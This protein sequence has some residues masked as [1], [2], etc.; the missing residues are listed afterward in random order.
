M[1]REKFDARGEYLKHNRG[2]LNRYYFCSQCIKPLTVHNME[3]DHIFPVSKWFGINRVFNCVAI[4][5]DCNKKK[6]NKAGLWNVEYGKDNKKNIKF[7]SIKGIIAKILEELLILIQNLII[8]ILRLI[9]LAIMSFIAMCFR[10]LRT[11]RSVVQKGLLIVTYCY[12]IN[13]VTT[14]LIGR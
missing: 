6:S 3:V 14:M 4:C 7:Y 12:V 2:I 1:K 8:W 13:L 5:P 10:P 11:Q 9:A